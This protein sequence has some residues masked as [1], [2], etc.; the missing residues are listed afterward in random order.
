MENTLNPRIVLKM[1]VVSQKSSVRHYNVSLS[2][3][4]TTNT[5]KTQKFSGQMREESVEVI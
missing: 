2:M 3:K 1:K 5:G 4:T